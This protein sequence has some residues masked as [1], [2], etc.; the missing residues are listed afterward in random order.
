MGAR[1]S[2]RE[3]T[4]PAITPCAPE[5]AMQSYTVSL[6]SVGGRSAA[7][8]LVHSL[9]PSTV[10]YTAFGYPIAYPWEESR[11][12]TRTA[13]LAPSSLAQVRPPSTVDQIPRSVTSQPTES[14]RKNSETGRSF[15]SICD[16]CL[17]PSLV[18]TTIPC[19]LPFFSEITP[20]A[21]QRFAEGQ[22]KSRISKAE[23]SFW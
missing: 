11:K 14:L 20:A 1:P 23:S 15:T 13:P 4:L 22:T 18:K 9:P 5:N 12:C 17:P 8:S 10:S 21:L 16:H 3:S 19:C 7:A 6:A 2:S